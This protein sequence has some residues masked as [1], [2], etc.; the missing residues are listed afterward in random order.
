ME[1]NPTSLYKV[2]KAFELEVGEKIYA[3]TPGQIYEFTE[4]QAA[5]AGDAIAKYEDGGND[6]ETTPK[7]EGEGETGGEGGKTTPQDDPG[8][9]KAGEPAT[10]PSPEPKG[11]ETQKPAPGNVGAE[12]PTT[13]GKRP[14]EIAKPWVGGHSVMGGKK[15]R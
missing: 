8:A 7:G 15:K 13:G 12:V 5:K 1:T 14:A 11:E 10:E 4:E 3:Y 6:P 2:I 9:P